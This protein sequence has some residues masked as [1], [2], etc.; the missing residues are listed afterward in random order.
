MITYICRNKDIKTGEDLPCTNTVCKTSV[1]PSCGQRADAGSGREAA[2]RAHFGDTLCIFRE[3]CV[4][5]FRKSLL[6][7]WE[8]NS[9]FRKGFKTT[10]Y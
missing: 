5:W 1:C 4:E 10:E 9:F 7:R 8:E 3:V 6:C 2:V